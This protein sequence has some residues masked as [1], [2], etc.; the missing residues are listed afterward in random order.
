MCVMQALSP[1]SVSDDLNDTA[2]SGKSLDVQSLSPTME[3]TTT[4]TT[5][6][7]TTPAAAQASSSQST[8]PPSASRPWFQ[9]YKVDPIDDKIFSQP[10]QLQMTGGGG[11]QGSLPQQ[12]RTI[13]LA[14]T[15]PEEEKR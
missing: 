12:P 15:E 1:S 14:A 6:T 8:S 11:G 5:T 7:T 13:D 3:N 2:T 10:F 9:W 4:A